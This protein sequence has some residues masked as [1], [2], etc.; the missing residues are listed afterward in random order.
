MKNMDGGCYYQYK[1]MRKC[2]C[3]EKKNETSIS[4]SFDKQENKTQKVN[5][6]YEK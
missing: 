1:N 4:T 5:S 6:K 2:Q 3:S